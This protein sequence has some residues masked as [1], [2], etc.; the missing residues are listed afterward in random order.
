MRLTGLS[1][2]KVC[3][4]FM[5]GSVG[6]KVLDGDAI[7][8]ALDVAIPA[9]D[10]TKDKVP[11]QGFL[12]LPDLFDAVRCGVGLRTTNPDD[13]HA[14]EHR[15][16]VNLYLKP[17]LA[18]PCEGLA[19]IVYTLDAYLADPQVDEEENRAL[20]VMKTTHVLVALLAFAG[21]EA[22]VDEVRFV[23]N[24]AGGNKE[25]ED[26]TIEKAK[27]EAGKVKEYHDRWCVVAE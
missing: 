12:K 5:D 22:P 24:L 6:T 13:F 10:F 14:K 18:A 4:A 9:H 25:T 15:G 20:I 16:R 2:S 7:L 3:T 8:S 19:A 27:N 21:P 1:I 11:G 17:H 23:S 26:W